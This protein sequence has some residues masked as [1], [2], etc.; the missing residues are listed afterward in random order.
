MGVGK[1][2]L[3]SPQAQA[4]SFFYCHNSHHNLF[5]VKVLLTT[6]G[7]NRVTLLFPRP[8]DWLNTEILCLLIGQV[9]RTYY[10]EFDQSLGLNPPSVCID[11]LITPA[12]CNVLAVIMTL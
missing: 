6:E 5:L 2:C 10:E 1:V 8:S 9:I 11:H 7:E 3:H 4:Q 12:I